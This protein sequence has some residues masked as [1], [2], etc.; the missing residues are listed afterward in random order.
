MKDIKDVD[1]KDKDTKY[2]RYQ[3]CPR[4]YTKEKVSKKRYPVKDD[5]IDKLLI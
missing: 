3:R 5:Q 4:K 2:E 1:T